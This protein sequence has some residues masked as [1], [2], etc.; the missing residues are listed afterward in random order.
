MTRKMKTMK[1][2]MKKMKKK[3]IKRG[4]NMNIDWLFTMEQKELKETLKKCLIEL[5][6]SKNVFD[7]DGFLY[8]KGEHPVLLVAHM[9][10]VHKNQVSR[11]FYTED[12]RYAT[13]IEGIGGD[14]RC[15]VLIILNIIQEINC[16]VL[17]TE[18]E[19]IGGV[20]AGKF[21]DSGIKLD[22]I[23]F[24]V[25][26]DRKGDNDFVFYK[27]PN[28]EFQEYVES[29]GFKE[30][31]GSYSDISDIANEFKI[32]AVNI[33]SGYFNPH[34]TNEYI[35]LVAVKDIID[36]GTKLIKGGTKKYEYQEDMP[37]KTT[38][39]Y[40]DYIYDDASGAWLKSSTYDDDDDWDDY[41][42]GDNWY[43]YYS[44]PIHLDKG[45]VVVKVG[46]NPIKFD[47]V[48]M[49][50]KNKVFRDKAQKREIVGAEVYEIGK[51][52]STSSYWVLKYRFPNQEYDMPKSRVKIINDVYQCSFCG[53]KVDAKNFY[54]S[55]MMC[56]PCYEEYNG[57]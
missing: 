17:F 57:I 20:G 35:D 34:T 14:D 11:V 18:D 31:I 21:C 19:E 33:S 8:A 13:A 26:F 45:Q 3:I 44:R 40:G 25:E 39:Y 49:N 36:R 42:K 28:D 30:G 46:G 23:N 10:T 47:R 4:D 12:K 43:E 2:T 41:Y 38:K 37:F 1:I 32:E 29:F 9:D 16:S 27:T 5:Y 53:K 51:D 15:G 50:N 54:K 55:T 24:A 6:G 7:E 48:F 52:F 56:K 22:D